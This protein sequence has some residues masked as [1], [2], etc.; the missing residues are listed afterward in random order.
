METLKISLMADFS[1]HFCVFAPEG[2]FSSATPQM[3]RKHQYYQDCNYIIA[4]TSVVALLAS[5][6][7]C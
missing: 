2:R 4:V 6:G 1:A 5:R 3:I 7:E